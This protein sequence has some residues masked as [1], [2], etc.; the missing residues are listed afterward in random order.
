MQTPEASRSHQILMAWVTGLNGKRER[1]SSPQ[2][3]T[4]PLLCSVVRLGQKG[5]DR[6][7]WELGE[8]QPPTIEGHSLEGMWQ[9]GAALTGEQSRREPHPR[10][11]NPR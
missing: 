3:R 2:P 9:V 10:S 6:S 11:G 5:Q 1:F 4:Q 7:G 8:D